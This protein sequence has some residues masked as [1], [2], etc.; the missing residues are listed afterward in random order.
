M[1]AVA[2]LSLL[3][4]LG[5]GSG[6][7]GGVDRISTTELVTHSGDTGGPGNP[8]GGSG[9]CVW[10]FMGSAVCYNGL[11]ESGCNDSLSGGF[12]TMTFT[13]NTTCQSLGYTSCSS[14]GG[15]S[16]CM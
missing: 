15:Y 14:Q 4:A 2:L 16:V 12:G 7:Q 11:P 1:S 9:A 3:L 6:D 5:C 8:G 13:A 10:E